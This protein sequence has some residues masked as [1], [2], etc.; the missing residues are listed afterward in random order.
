MPLTV[1]TV[2]GPTT[3]SDASYRGDTANTARVRATDVLLGDPATIVPVV[4]G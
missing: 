1:V 2:L 3:G 4:T